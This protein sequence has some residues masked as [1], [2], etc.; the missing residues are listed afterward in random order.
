MK[1]ILQAGMARCRM[2]VQNACHHNDKRKS[3]RE[4]NKQSRLSSSHRSSRRQPPLG[5]LTPLKHFCRKL[6]FQTYGRK[7]S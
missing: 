4:T 2:S 7:A 6:V 3:R 5:T 1:P